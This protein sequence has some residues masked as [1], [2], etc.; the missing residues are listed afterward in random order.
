M[1][2]NKLGF[3][4]ILALLGFMGFTVST[5]FFGFFGFAQ[6]IR[7]FFVTPDEMFQQNLRK[8]ASYGFFSGIWVT[9]LAIVVHFLFPAFLPV[10]IALISCYV[11]AVICFTISLVVLEINEQREIEIWP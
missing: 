6:Y 2:V 9:S 11:V 8:S 4:S 7:Y 1:K 10:N 5:P 3:L